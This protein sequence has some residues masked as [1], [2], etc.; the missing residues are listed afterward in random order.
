M[1][2][3]KFTTREWVI[4]VQWKYG[5]S[6]WISLKEIKDNHPVEIFD[7]SLVQG[8]QDEPA[9]AWWVPYVH[10]KSKSIIAKLKYK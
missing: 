1:K 9:F 10:N 3:K 8:I 7:C 5:S 4:M 2:Q 6:D